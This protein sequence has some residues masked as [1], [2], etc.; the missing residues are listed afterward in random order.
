VAASYGGSTDRDGIILAVDVA[1]GDR[2]IVSGHDPSTFSQDVPPEDWLYVGDGPRFGSVL[3]VQRAPDGSLLAWS[4]FQDPTDRRVFRVDPSTGNREI[5]W[6]H[7]GTANEW[8][9]CL[10]SEGVPLQTSD[11]GFAVDGEGRVYVGISNP[12]TGR[13]IIRLSAAFDACEVLTAYGATANVGG[14]VDIGGFIQGYSRYDDKLYAFSTQPKQLFSVD[15]Q[16]GHR[17]GILELAGVA[18]PERWPLWDENRGVWW[19]VGFQNAVTIDV[20]EPGGVY[21]SIFQG[22]EMFDWMPLGAAGP[23]QINALNYAP[24]WL[25]SNGNLLVAQDGLSIVEYEPTTGSS[26]IISL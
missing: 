23:V 1:T 15:L 4:R 19:L 14:G 12:L 8:P 22:G 9:V 16:T 2:R 3:D 6:G 10:D 25:R 21:T 17:E 5:V 11:T 7:D 13:G 24:V 18:P 20:W 26:V